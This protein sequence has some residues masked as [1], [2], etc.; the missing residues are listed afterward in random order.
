MYRNKILERK[1]QDC[2]L[3]SRIDLRREKL[4]DSDIEFVIQE[5]IINK[6][7]TMLWLLDNQLTSHS[8]SILA[9]IFYTN[10]TLE[11]LS[12]CQNNITDADLLYLTKSLSNRKC[13]LNRLALT[14]NQITDQGV[15]YLV[16][17]LETNQSLTQL[18]LGSN[19]ITDYGVQLLMDVLT[20]HNRTLRILS[21]S[22]NQLISDL[23]IDFILH[24]LEHNQI[25]QMISLLNCNLSETSQIQ[26]QEAA[27]IR[28]GFN[29]DF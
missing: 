19:Q 26:L 20:T 6:Q 1:I 16:E 3:L 9:S 23:C 12:L 13:K 17:M 29:F 10:T 7:C 24:M 15:Q 5:G 18:W 14:S 25:L 22:K 4:T 11:G 2:Q 21:L 8:I 28:L 27:K